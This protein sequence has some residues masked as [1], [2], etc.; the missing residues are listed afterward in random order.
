MSRPKPITARTFG[1]R[2][3][4]SATSGACSASTTTSVASEL[5]ITYCISSALKR[6]ES[7]TAIWPALRAAWIVVTTSSEFGPHQTRRSP[8]SIPRLRSACASR[9]TLLLSC[10]NVTAEGRP[11]PASSTVTAARSPDASACRA[12]RS[13]IRLIGKPPESRR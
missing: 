11:P 2:S 7:G 1:M 10:S 6:Y 8:R 12:N 9:F 3:R 5:S 13:G 4:I